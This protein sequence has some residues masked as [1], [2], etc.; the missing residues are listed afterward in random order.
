[1]QMRGRVRDVVQER[2]SIVFVQLPEPQQYTG[3]NFNGCA[4]GPRRR[5]LPGQVIQLWG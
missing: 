2:D 4:A 1:M 5:G 3:K